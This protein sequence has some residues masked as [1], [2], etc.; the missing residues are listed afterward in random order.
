MMYCDVLPRVVLCCA[1]L[2]MYHASKESFL[3]I[4][5][6]YI[7]EL[8]P[9]DRALVP[10]G[11]RQPPSQDFL[12]QL[13]EFTTWRQAMQQQALAQSQQASMFKSF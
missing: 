11:G 10:L 6:F 3:Y 12:Q 13:R 4:E 8:L 1:V 5:E 7:G 9:A 2:Q